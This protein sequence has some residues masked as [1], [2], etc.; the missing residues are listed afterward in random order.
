MAKNV[1]KGIDN[2]SGDIA[3]MPTTPKYLLALI[4]N[5]L[6]R[7]ILFFFLFGKNFFIAHSE[8]KINSSDKKTETDEPKKPA[9]TPIKTTLKNEK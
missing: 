7:V 2:M 9:V 8:S 4:K 5:R 3:A 1:P 6:V